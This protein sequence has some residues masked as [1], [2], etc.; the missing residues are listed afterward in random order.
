MHRNI[1]QWGTLYNGA[2]CVGDG[3]FGLV[4]NSQYDQCSRWCLIRCPRRGA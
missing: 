2:Y 4:G 1:T 3:T